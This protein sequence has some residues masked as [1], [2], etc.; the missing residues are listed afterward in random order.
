MSFQWLEMRIAEEQDRR[1]RQAE[2]LER[3][4]RALEE[5]YRGLAACVDDYT[6]AFGG[7]AAQVYL[8]SSK[9]RVVIRE[10]TGGDW[11]EAAS[12][13]IASVPSLPGFQIERG[14]KQYIVEVGLLPGEK[15]SYK[16]RELDQYLTMDELTRRILD[17]LLFPKLSE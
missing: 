5:L 10:D 9:I 12:V 4:P 16:D 11:Q 6:Q 17:R 13:E 7:E 3:L 2:I 15:V 1:A 14:S 8:D